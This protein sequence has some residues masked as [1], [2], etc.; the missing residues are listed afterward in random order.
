MAEL[1]EPFADLVGGTEWAL[2]TERQR[3]NKRLGS[4]QAS[5][6][7][8]YKLMEPRMPGIVDYLAQFDLHND[9]SADVKTLYLMAL[10][11]MEVS[12]S[13][14]RFREPDESGVFAAER[15]HVRGPDEVIVGYALKTG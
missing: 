14:E 5:L 8:Y 2:P 12:I 4:S 15:Y 13:V 6:E 1:P 11:Y 7:D 3:F 9:L 10:A